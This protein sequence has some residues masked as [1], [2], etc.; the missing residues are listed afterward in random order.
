MRDCILNSTLKRRRPVSSGS[1]IWDC[2]DDQE[3]D[4]PKRSHYPQVRSTGR[5]RPLSSTKEGEECSNGRPDRSRNNS[6]LRRRRPSSPQT[7]SQEVYTQRDPAPGPTAVGEHGQ[8]AK[9]S[10]PQKGRQPSLQGS[11][12]ELSSHGDSPFSSRKRSR[13]PMQKSTLTKKSKPLRDRRASPLGSSS[14]SLSSDLSDNLAKEE[15]PT[16]KPGKSKD[17][18]TTTSSTTAKP[19][20]EKPTTSSKAMAKAA[21][22]K[23]APSSTKE[24]AA[25]STRRTASS[26]TTE[27]TSSKSKN[28]G[29]AKG[30][31]PAQSAKA[32]DNV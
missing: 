15:S 3:Q 23:A 17:K 12:Q 7:S 30:K 5:R 29:K 16:K 27:D 8:P 4:E 20:K 2:P 24:T 10:A 18:A 32:D 31:A 19:R 14:S 21:K 6:G 28:K 22:D 25:P 11:S 26:K 1:S 9:R 13:Q